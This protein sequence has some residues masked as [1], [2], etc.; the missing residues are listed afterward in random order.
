MDYWI[1]VN[2]LSLHLVLFFAGSHSTDAYTKLVGKIELLNKGLCFAISLTIA[3]LLLA[4]LPYTLVRYYMFHME[5][6]SFHLFCPSWFVLY[7]PWIKSPHYWIFRVKKI[8]LSGCWSVHVL[9]KN[10]A[11]NCFSMLKLFSTTVKG[12]WTYLQLWSRLQQIE[13]NKMILLILTFFSNFHLA[14]QIWP[15]LGNR[16]IVNVFSVWTRRIELNNFDQFKTQPIYCNWPLLSS[17]RW[18]Y[19]LKYIIFI[20]NCYRMI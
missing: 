17:L 3:S 2:E 12:L 14:T 7:L 11:K 19:Q 20:E 15:N 5:E 8:D 16:L 10:L 18:H 1:N 6:E 13:N 9:D 4:G